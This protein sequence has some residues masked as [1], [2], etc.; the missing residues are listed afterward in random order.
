MTTCS[1]PC[2]K[3][4]YYV[5][6]FFSSW[7]SLI[8]ST[9]P[10]RGDAKKSYHVIVLPTLEIRQFSQHRPQEVMPKKCYHVN[11]LPLLENWQ[12]PR[13]RPQEVMPKNCYHVKKWNHV[14]VFACLGNCQ[15][16]RHRPQEVMRY[17]TYFPYLL[18]QRMARAARKCFQYITHV[19]YGI[20]K[21]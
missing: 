5:N 13:H 1:F 12:F 3:R 20:L 16:P 18:L 17:L 9:S 7:K 14:N 11:V 4:R 15:F 6:V 19:S 10:P 21:E 8:F 2:C